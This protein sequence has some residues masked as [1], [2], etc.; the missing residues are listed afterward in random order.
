MPGR[1][2]GRVA[3]V[4]GAAGGIG[5]A[6]AEMMAGEGAIVV[7]TDIAAP[8]SAE[9]LAG[10]ERRGQVYRPADLSTDDAA[11][12]LVAH[13]VA[14]H[15][16]LDVLFCIHGISEAEPF[17]DSDIA[18]LDRMLTVNVRSVFLTCR[19][20]ARAMVEG[21]G[22][23]IV[24]V[25][26]SSA[27]KPMPTLVAYSATKAAV[28]QMTRVMALE[29]A[30]T[31]IRVNAICPGVIDTAMPY[32][33]VSSLPPDEQQAAIDAMAAHHP[34]G[35]L[36]RPEEIAALGVHLASDEASF[37]TGAIIPA[38]GGVSAS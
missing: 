20:A 7:P 13:T 26:S 19:A 28:I 35:R 33:A 23:S 4:T 6:A 15:G 3:I 12:E 21:G 2:E 11:D 16:R 27:L 14:E 25:A 30:Q 29:L 38:D 5:R 10:F 24:N 18:R 17:L 34:V 22:G 37:T 31:G 1:L 32:R 9:A 36:G 8:P